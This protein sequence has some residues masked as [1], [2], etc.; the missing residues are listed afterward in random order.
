MSLCGQHVQRIVI[1]I[2][3]VHAAHHRTNGQMV[4]PGKSIFSGLHCFDEA[5]LPGDDIPGQQVVTRH[6]TVYTCR[7]SRTTAESTLAIPRTALRCG[8][9]ILRQL[10]GLAVAGESGQGIV[11]HGGVEEIPVGPDISLRKALHSAVDIVSDRPDK[12]VSCRGRKRPSGI[13]AVQHRGGRHP[14]SRQR[15]TPGPTH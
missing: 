1:T 5:Q 2:A 8:R 15:H 14:G 9:P 10:A 11:A 6:L 13:V 3:T 7:P 12:N 4:G